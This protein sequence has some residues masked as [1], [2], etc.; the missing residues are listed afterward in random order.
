MSDTRERDTIHAPPLPESDLPT[1]TRHNVDRADLLV[2]VA[3]QLDTVSQQL[4]SVARDMA[5]AMGQGQ[6]QSLTLG[7][8]D[9]RLTALELG[10]QQLKQAVAPLI[11]DGK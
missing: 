6:T 10:V 3:I 4:A 9:R 2:S 11:G 7:E 8:H 1:G 5:F